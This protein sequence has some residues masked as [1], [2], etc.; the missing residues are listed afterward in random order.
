MSR[1]A[2]MVRRCLTLKPNGQVLA[3][4]SGSG[5]IFWS[6]EDVRSGK[7]S[8]WTDSYTSNVAIPG[9]F[10]PRAGAARVPS[11]GLLGRLLASPAMQ[12]SK[13]AGV[14]INEKPRQGEIVPG[15][16]LKL[17]TNSLMPIA[18]GPRGLSTYALQHSWIASHKSIN[19]LACMNPRR[20][21][22]KSCLERQDQPLPIRYMDPHDTT[23]DLGHN[24]PSHRLKLLLLSTTSSVRLGHAKHTVAPHASS[25]K[26]DI[27]TR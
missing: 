22:H 7:I 13:I 1:R 2:M 9:N 20:R 11:C 27:G 15:C 19:T 12:L 23:Q 5:D 18:M 3:T 25:F 16:E 14:Y 24:V 26:P 21:L 6:A 17:T 10:R 8:Q 4:V